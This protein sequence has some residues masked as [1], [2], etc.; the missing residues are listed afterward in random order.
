MYDQQ[1]KQLRDSALLRELSALVEQERVNSAKLLACIAEVDARRL[2]RPAGYPSMYAY[3]LGELRLSEDVAYKRIRAARAARQFPGLLRAVARGR[4]HLSAVCLLAPHLTAKN[5]NELIAAAAHK[6]RS[7]LERF[8]ARRFPLPEELRIDDGVAPLPITRFVPV[9]AAGGAQRAPEPVAPGAQLA[10]GRVSAE[11]ETPPG[12]EAPAAELA[13]GRVQVPSPQTRLSPLSPERYVIQLTISRATHDKLRRAQALL[14]HSIP[15]GDVA[16]VL[17]RALDF[18]IGRLEQRKLGA[19]SQPRRLPRPS[20]GRRHVPAA[21]R[22]EVWERDQG[23]CTF[24]G[25]LGRRCEAVSRLEFDHV[26]PVALGGQATVERMRLRCR[27]HNQLEA[28]RTFGGEF[29]RRKRAAAVGGRS[30][31]GGDDQALDV[32]ADQ[33]VSIEGRLSLAL[34]AQRPQGTVRGGERGA[35][36]AGEASQAPADP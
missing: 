26:D 4:L 28:E 31:A 34:G 30:S 19:T 22:R 17:D 7:D 13:P 21:V 18:L 2:Y 10:P 3:C 29:M 9:E 32:I 33:P 16:S 5:A 14:G 12:R 25:D 6:S 24:V 35:A 20:S 36:P 23:R 8:L 11:A 15:S 1:L 27:A